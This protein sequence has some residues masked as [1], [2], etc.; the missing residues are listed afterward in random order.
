PARPDD[1]DGLGDQLADPLA[2]AEWGDR[3]RND[4]QNA[5]GYLA[6]GPR[7]ATIMAGRGRTPPVL[8][9]TPAST[10]RPRDPSGSGSAVS[11]GNR[12]RPADGETRDGNSGGARVTDRPD[13]DHDG[14]PAIHDA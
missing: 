4:H 8:H 1:A 7:N 10:R 14:A 3:E 5:S 11:V 9:P 13:A 2:Y 12:P 6:L